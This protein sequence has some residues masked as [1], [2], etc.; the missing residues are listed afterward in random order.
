MIILWFLSDNC[1]H[2]VCELWIKH[3]NKIVHKLFVTRIKAPNTRDLLML[4]IWKQITPDLR[5]RDVIIC[6]CVKISWIT[7]NHNQ[8]ELLSQFTDSRLRYKVQFFWATRGWEKVH[9]PDLK[10]WFIRKIITQDF[11]VVTGEAEKWFRP[12]GIDWRNELQFLLKTQIL[13]TLPLVCRLQ[14]TVRL[15]KWLLILG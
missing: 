14:V 4:Y 11:V 9:W 10:H 6:E 3:Y 5:S 1:T 15:V 8:T 13:W 2:F 7:V 12:R